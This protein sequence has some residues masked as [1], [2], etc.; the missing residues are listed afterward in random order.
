MR[1]I[2]FS[3]ILD[4]SLYNRKFNSSFSNTYIRQTISHVIYVID[5]LHLL[6]NNWTNRCLLEKFRINNLLDSTST[7]SYYYFNF[8]RWNNASFMDPCHRNISC[9]VSEDC[10]KKYYEIFLSTVKQIKCMK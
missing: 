10:I 8:I 9:K 1:S 5:L 7:F 3:V 2:V 6:Y 4:G